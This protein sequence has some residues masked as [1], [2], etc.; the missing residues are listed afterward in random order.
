MKSGAF[1][2]S[3]RVARSNKT[4]NLVI[5]KAQSEPDNIQ[6]LANNSLEKKLSYDIV[7]LFIIDNM[8]NSFNN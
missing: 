1:F 3:L 2:H 5:S 8:D 6:K 4:R 7:N